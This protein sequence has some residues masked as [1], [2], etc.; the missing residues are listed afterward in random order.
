MQASCT[1]LMY[2]GHQGTAQ[3]TTSGWSCTPLALAWTTP[4]RLVVDASDLFKYLEPEQRDH[5]TCL[6]LQSLQHQFFLLHVSQALTI[7]LWPRRHSGITTLAM[8]PGDSVELDT[9]SLLG[10]QMVQ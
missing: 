5:L 6:P 1:F 3:K 9:A 8:D 2:T 7:L 4:A 10:M